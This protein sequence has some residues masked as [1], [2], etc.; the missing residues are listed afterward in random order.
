MRE[1]RVRACVLS[2]LLL[3]AAASAD[4]VVLNDGTH[5]DGRVANREWSRDGLLSASIIAIRDEAGEWQQFGPR[6]IL[7]VILI[8]GDSHEVIEFSQRTGGGVANRGAAMAEVSF[9]RDHRSSTRDFLI[10]GG[11]LSGAIGAGKKFGGPK[12]EITEE[13]LDVEKESYNGLNYA[14]MVAGAGMILAG[15]LME[16]GGDEI[17]VSVTPAASPLTDAPALVCSVRF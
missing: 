14:M 17:P 5:V 12:V 15:I 13:G 16:P 3:A 11:F 9:G 7:C 2:L 6:Q 1:I 10:L 4:L 8:D